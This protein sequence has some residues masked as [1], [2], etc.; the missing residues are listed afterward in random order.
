M[1]AEKMNLKIYEM[2]TIERLL[3]GKQKD[4]L[5]YGDIKVL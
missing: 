3:S 2:E 1:V 5:I 4:I